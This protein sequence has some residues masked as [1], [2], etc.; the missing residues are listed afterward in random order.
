MT[1]HKNHFDTDEQQL[2]AVIRGLTK[3][4]GRFNFAVL[5]GNIPAAWQ[6]LRELKTFLETVEWPK[7]T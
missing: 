1:P 2:D 7:S 5:T 4:V 3:Y 6:A